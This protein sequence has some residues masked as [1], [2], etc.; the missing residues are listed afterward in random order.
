MNILKT[1]IGNKEV[2]TL[3]RFIR[4]NFDCVVHDTDD[5]N[6]I[7]SSS[8]IE[9]NKIEQYVMGKLTSQMADIVKRKQNNNWRRAISL[10]IKC[11]T[12]HNEDYIIYQEATNK[13]L[14]ANKQ[15]K[16]LKQ[17]KSIKHKHQQP[18]ENKIS[19]ILK[20]FTKKADAPTKSI[21]N[22]YVRGIINSYSIYYGVCKNLLNDLRVSPI[23]LNSDIQHYIEIMRDIAAMCGFSENKVLHLQQNQWPDNFVMHCTSNQIMRNIIQPIFMN[24]RYQEMVYL[25]ICFMTRLQRQLIIIGQPTLLINKYSNLINYIL[26]RN[27]NFD[28]N[29]DYLDNDGERVHIQDILTLHGNIWK[30][31]KVLL[32]SSI[33]TSCDS[34]VNIIQSIDHDD[35]FLLIF[36]TN[37][38]IEYDIWNNPKQNQLRYESW[39]NNPIYHEE[40]KNTILVQM[41]AIQTMLHFIS[42]TS[43]KCIQRSHCK[44]KNYLMNLIPN[45]LDQ[46]LYFIKRIADRQQIWH[47]IFTGLVF[48]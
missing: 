40:I 29:T 18:E 6:L 21:N 3:E 2:N 10:F 28:T 41:N 17:F 24:C 23:K 1:Q 5:K 38:I 30:F 4:G 7:I 36:Q 44:K 35:F 13:T 16:I 22:E 15:F 27:N 47:E 14:I 43:C 39:L 19:A 34:I 12:L 45:Y 26:K 37:D 20:Y 32:D 25:L 48:L 33:D 31:F 8:W 9:I 11:K 42:T 46:I